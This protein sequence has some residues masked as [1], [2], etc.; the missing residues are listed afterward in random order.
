MGSV[1]NSIDKNAQNF[2]ITLS[3]QFGK[4]V[5]NKISGGSTIQVLP[6]IGKTSTTV[7]STSG[8]SSTQAKVTKDVIRD[9]TLQL[10][11]NYFDIQELLYN[12]R[13]SSSTGMTHDLLYYVPDDNWF[14]VDT[15]TIIVNDLGNVGR[16]STAA[17]A[18]S[19]TSNATA[20]KEFR[21]TI[22]LDIQSVQD[23]PVISPPTGSFNYDYL[24]QKD[25]K[26]SFGGN[27]TGVASG[28]NLIYLITME[29]MSGIIGVDCCNWVGDL[30]NTAPFTS[31]SENGTDISIYN[32][33]IHMNLSFTSFQISDADVRVMDRNTRYIVRHVI[34][35]IEKAKQVATDNGLAFNL[36]VNSTSTN[37]SSPI[38]HYSYVN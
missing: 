26:Y 12:S 35:S 9:T 5:Y 29:D 27:G 20:A 24:M 15:L 14:G 2:Q 11:G 38:Y 34:G 10:R 13:T 32:N 18:R 22:L 30:N 28:N 4:I 16:S 19:T 7:F 3:V 21:R 8:S 17:N 31:S 33:E 25:M 1:Q 23:L 36:T 37:V 6:S